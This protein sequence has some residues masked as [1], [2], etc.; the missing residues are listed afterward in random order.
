MPKLAVSLT[1]LTADDEFNLGW[2]STE[3]PA[4]VLKAVEKAKE[5]HPSWTSLIVSIVNIEAFKP[6]PLTKDN[7][8]QLFQLPFQT[9]FVGKRNKS[10]VY[11][12]LGDAPPDTIDKIR[13]A[14]VASYMGDNIWTKS[15]DE[16]MEEEWNP[17][18]DVWVVDLD[19]YTSKPPV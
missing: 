14:I 10:L 13:C 1:V 11:K 7:L 8:V 12:V 17:Y 4:D 19:D 6:K 18:A 2:P 3:D 5:E 9:Y 16:K 15:D